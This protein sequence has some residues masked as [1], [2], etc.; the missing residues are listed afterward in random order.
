MDEPVL[1]S[2]MGPEQDVVSS[3]MIKDP[4]RLDVNRTFTTL[5]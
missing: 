1:L 3:K 4:S 2:M 5:S